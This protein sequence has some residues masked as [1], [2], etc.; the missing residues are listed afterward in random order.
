MTPLF[1]APV[2]FAGRAG[3]LQDKT[4]G[5]PGDLNQPACGRL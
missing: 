5:V 3:P 2:N 1:H 4:G